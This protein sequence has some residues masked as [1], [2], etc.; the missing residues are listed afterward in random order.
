M[1]ETNE[2]TLTNMM[3]LAD[4][5]AVHVAAAALGGSFKGRYV[6]PRALTRDE[7]EI[8]R[9][10]KAVIDAISYLRDGPTVFFADCNGQDALDTLLTDAPVYC[11]ILLEEIDLAPE[12]EAQADREYDI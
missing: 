1:P 6:E 9:R 5:D 12:R 4:K 8:K 2:T 7:M 11:G 3:S 10:I